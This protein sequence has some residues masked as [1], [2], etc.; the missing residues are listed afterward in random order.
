MHGSQPNA[1]VDRLAQGRAVVFR[2]AT[3][4]TVDPAAGSTAAGAANGAGGAS[5]VI[6]N[7]DVLVIGEQIQAVGRSLAAP[8]DAVEID[9][10][11]GILMPGM[12][13]THRHMWQTAQRGLGADW[14]LT[15]YFYFYYVNWGH[16]MRPEDVYAGNLLAAIESVDAGVTTTVDWS[17]GL[18][19]VDH[20]EA[21]VDALESVPGRF[22]LA[23]GNLAQAPWE[24]AT[25][26][27]FRDFVE[28]RLA[29]RGD[30]LGWQIAF[31]VT[32]DP[33][34]PEEAAFAVARE[35]DATVTTHSGVWA[36]TT[37]DSIRL[38]AEHGY[39][40][41]RLR[42]VH[43][44]SLS[45]DSYHRI[46]ASGGQAS[47]AAESECSAG[48]GFP[49]SWELRQYGI[50]ISLSV[51]TSVWWSADMFSAMRATLNADRIR[52][53]Q[54]AHERAETV[55][56]LQL[57]AE[58]VV[59]YGTQGGAD[60]IGLGD[61]IGSITAGKQ[62]DLVLVRNER[63]PVMFPVLNPAGHVVFQAQRA[64]VHTVMVNGRVLKYEHQLLLDDQV[65]RA[66]RAIAESVEH[67]RSAMGD[68]AWQ[69]AMHPEK[70]SVQP[71]DNP[72]QYSD[73]QPA[74]PSRPETAHEPS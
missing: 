4:L 69:A 6:E 71:V 73:F 29:S 49:S 26:P 13:D 56:N 52:E 55:M 43:V 23:Y 47:V 63:S 19:T 27:E 54:L 28:R 35:L 12:V 59:R 65:A 46:A 7:G 60:H 41:D 1:T 70:V 44:S 18:R 21:A 57:R 39:L 33:Q 5:G 68:E 53:H 58:D 10:S 2:G 74:E 50:P 24:W 66:R 22:V 72:Y 51:D 40:T 48:Q 62:A 37:D 11:G 17:H 9:A 38:I 31:D 67:V 3:V 45:P 14:S 61:R 42:H 20:A 8:D 34:F 25:S 30:M 64:D 15:N 16:V 36:V 32:G